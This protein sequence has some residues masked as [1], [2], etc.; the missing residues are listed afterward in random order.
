MAGP[1]RRR[2]DGFLLRVGVLIVIATVFLTASFVGVVG[3]ISGDIRG[4]GGRVPWYIVAAAVTFVA[5]VVLL[6]E[7][8]AA[9]RPIMI[10]AAFFTMPIFIVALLGT[11]GPIHILTN[12]APIFAPD[13]PLYSLS[14]VL[15]HEGVAYR[16][17]THRPE[18][19]TYLAT[20]RTRLMTRRASY[21]ARPRSANM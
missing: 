5:S 14:A 8:G 3:F 17:F 20:V 1:M 19:T 7:Q 10:T 9:G 15:F 21:I 4:F 2:G 11:Q 13:V 6:E 18:L 16:A 12:P